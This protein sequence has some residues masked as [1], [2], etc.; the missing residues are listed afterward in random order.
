[1]PCSEIRAEW[2]AQRI[3]GLS[4]LSAV[5]NAL[6]KHHR[7]N[8]KGIAKTLI[9]SFDYPKL[10][11]GMMW[12]SV[13]RII[14]KHGS[15]VCLENEVEEITWD[16]QKN[17]VISIGVKVKGKR[18][19]V[20]G[21]HFISSM[22]LKEMIQKFKQA[23]PKEVLDAAN[24]LNY[25]DFLTVAL[26][27]NK[28]ELFPDN[29]IYIH[30][31]MV[32]LGRVQNFKNWSP[33]MVSDRNKSCLGLEYF[34]T[35]GDELWNMQDKE[36]IEL[37]KRELEVIGLVKSSDIVDGSVVR[38]PKAYPTYDS[39]YREMIDI[40]RRFLKSIKNLQVVG[41][42]GLHRYNNQDHSM[43]TAML[44]VENIYGANHDLWSVNEDREYHEN[45]PPHST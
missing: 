14:R 22:P 24:N 42:N 18:K 44:A 20:Y 27:V 17:R 45:K 37:G 15:R 11:P 5:R 36:L 33:Y 9:D 12:Q 1:M 2:A 32:K 26:I 40:I 30:D 31:P 38:M 4:L 6:T 13:S 21:K 23:V 39:K 43:Y 10:G 8:G 34:C 41:R 25:R 7:N 19:R 29:W 28:S 16:K 35:E 3:K